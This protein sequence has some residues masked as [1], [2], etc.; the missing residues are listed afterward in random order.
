MGRFLSS[1]SSTTEVTWPFVT[2]IRTLS[3]AMMW[4][5]TQPLPRISVDL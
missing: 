1:S 4:F 5:S 2:W 3:F